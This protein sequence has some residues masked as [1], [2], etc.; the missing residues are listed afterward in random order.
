ME[1][2]GEGA[3]STPLH[4]LRALVINEAIGGRLIIRWD[5][6]RMIVPGH[7]T[8]IIVGGPVR[9]VD[10][11]AVNYL[12]QQGISHKTCVGIILISAI[13]AARID[14]ISLGN[15]LLRFRCRKSEG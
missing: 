13:A 2:S 11:H 7:S 5:Q 1:W 8:P 4:P 9:K 15:V 14:R 6:V 10:C 12:K 3:H